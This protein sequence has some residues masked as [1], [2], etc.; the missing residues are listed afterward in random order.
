MTAETT[1]IFT[2]QIREKILDESASLQA[3]HQKLGISGLVKAV[4]KRVRAT[5]PNIYVIADPSGTPLAGNLHAFD[6]SVL[7]KTGWVDPPFKYF[8]AGEP[9]RKQAQFEN[10]ALGYVQV[11]PNKMRVLVGHDMGEPARLNRLIA[12][13][14]TAVLATMCLGVLLIWFSVG[15]QALKRVDGVTN[16]S[17]QIMTGDLTQRLPVTGSGDEFD[18]LAQ[19]L[20][21]MLARIA[22]LN[23]AMRQISDNIAHDLKTPLTRLRNSAEEALSTKHS[24][25]AYR[26]VIEDMIRQADQIIRTFSALLMISRLDAGYSSEKMEALDLRAIARDVAELY[27]PV[28]EELGVTLEF[29]GPASVKVRG[30]RALLSQTLSNVV[31]NAI[32]Y[33]RKQKGTPKV[34]VYAAASNGIPSVQ[35]SDNGPGIKPEDF[36]RVTQR[37]VR[38]EKSRSEPGSGLG[39]SLAKAV[40][41]MHGGEFI[42]SEN[43][44]GLRVTLQFAKVQK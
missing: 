18:R 28:A 29:V 12:G 19:N 33:A 2:E 5:K 25:A 15:R 8:L 16:A 7:L 32:K 3:I 40:M 43:K 44:P 30:N 11:L 31:D 21:Q 13:S 36:D 9:D 17:K 23:D 35:V 39:L 14:L 38:L 41:K 22:E 34:S 27:E 20:N 1:R 42:L 6:T 37:F 26:A 10:L 4:D 24:A